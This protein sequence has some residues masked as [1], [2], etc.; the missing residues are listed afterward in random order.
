[1]CDDESKESNGDKGEHQFDV[2]NR[3]LEESIDAKQQVRYSKRTKLNDDELCE[4]E[5][6]ESCIRKMVERLEHINFAHEHNQFHKLKF[7][8]KLLQCLSPGRL[9]DL[10]QGTSAPEGK[11]DENGIAL[12]LFHVVT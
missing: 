10:L 8:R 5:F 7:V 4:I 6:T 12:M 11:P 1:M 3:L 2:A 9:T